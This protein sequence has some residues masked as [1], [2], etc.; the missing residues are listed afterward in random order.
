MF[1]TLYHRVPCSGPV[2]YHGVDY[3]EPPQSP[4]TLDRCVGR[5]LSSVHVIFAMLLAPVLLYVLQPAF[6]VQNLPSR[7]FS[8]QSP[9]GL[10]PSTMIALED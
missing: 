10:F 4:S 1:P 6:F 5:R 2:E 8:S 7:S 9:F 3:K